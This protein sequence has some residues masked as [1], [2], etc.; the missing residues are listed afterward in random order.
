MSINQ[1]LIK[2]D[3][4]L[5]VNGDW[6]EKAVIPADKPAT[7]GFTTL[8]DDIEDLLMADLKKM[9][10]G[11]IKLTNEVQEEMMKYYAQ[12][13][14]FEKR[15]QED[16][17]PLKPYIDKITT[18]QSLQDL[19][20]NA[21]ELALMDYTLPWSLGNATDFKNAEYYALYLD[22]PSLLL[23]DTTYYEDE[24]ETAEILYAAYRQVG[25]ALFQRM[26]WT[27]E[28]AQ[29]EMDRVFEL[30]QMMAPYQKSQE[31][32]AD[33]TIIYNPRDI[34]TVETYAKDFSFRQVI[35]KLIGKDVDRVIV[36]QPE[37][38]EH[39]ADIF[40]DKNIDLIKSWMTFYFVLGHG[41]LLSEEIRQLTSQINNAL[42]G[43][44]EAAPKEKAA[45]R[46]V[47]G[48]FSH[49]LGDYYGKK[50]FGEKARADI[51]EMVKEMIGV[52]EQ[53]LA[54][55]EWLSDETANKAIEKLD[56]M[57]ILVGYPDEIQPIFYD[58]HV[59]ES[60]SF[61]DNHM[62]L[63]AVHIADG[64]SKWNKKVDRKEWG[65]SASVVNA[66]F[67]PT[68]N[69]IC[70][71]AAILQAP[72]YSYEQSRSANYGGIGAVIAH[73]I[74]HAFDNNGAKVDKYGNIFN[75]WT[76]E[77]FA[78]FDQKA[79]EMVAQWDGIPYADG[80]VNGRLTVSEN[81][82]DLGGL[83]AALEALKHEDDADFKEFFFNWARV[84]AQ[85]A[86]PEM[87]NLLLTVDV[88]APSPLRA[89][90]PVQNLTEFYEVFGIEP[91]DKMYTA[92]E[93]RVQIW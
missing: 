65:M 61:F 37:F 82:A 29:A 40:N 35:D 4:Y 7:G 19:A 44:T 56:H 6:L 16:W 67:S 89:N 24:N 22:V 34:E 49:V 39:Y 3:L 68:A 50:Y 12:A 87:M 43:T 63:S 91:G 64:M 32:L 54:Q 10:D 33:Y 1:D 14:D 15:D 9:S 81:I 38:F 62:Q 30:D 75:W 52:Y 41:H 47:N 46:L 71:P 90:I 85:K 92:P 58:L 72:F 53:R 74:S 59:D 79:E 78:A 88:H 55:N 18:A 5:A 66:Y 42:T 13:T 70:F 60:Q 84:W 76:D 8:R 20:E 69:L 31:E 26:G 86:R 36:T 93:D 80:Q 28:E 17:Q 11:E 23:P 21:R 48:M 51:T 73:E 83:T 57:E 77:D 2:D 25:A 45:Y 27:S